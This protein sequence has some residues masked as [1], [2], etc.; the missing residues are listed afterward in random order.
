MFC[1]YCGKQLEDDWKFC[2]ICGNSVEGLE[3]RSRELFEN[4][5]KQMERDSFKTI[6]DPIRYVVIQKES[7]NIIEYSGSLARCNMESVEYIAAV[8]IGHWITMY[9]NR[10]TDYSLIA[11]F[12]KY[13]RQID[14]IP[15]SDEL[16]L[17]GFGSGEWYNMTYKF[18]NKETK[19]HFGFSYLTLT[20]TLKYMVEN[21]KR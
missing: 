6:S 4:K 21:L 15:A 3:P 18:R 11:F 16:E 7:S 2:P 8:H 1:R 14:A 5:V 9:G 12:D 17:Y 13:L 20:P 10:G 19:K